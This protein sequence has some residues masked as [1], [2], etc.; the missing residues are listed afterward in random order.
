L[1]HLPCPM[2]VCS[3]SSCV[4]VQASG[5]DGGRFNFSTVP[6]DRA[7]AQPYRRRCPAIRAPGSGSHSPMRATEII[8]QAPARGYLRA[9]FFDDQGVRQGGQL[10]QM[11]NALGFN[12]FS[13]GGF[14]CPASGP[15]ASANWIP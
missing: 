4:S 6:K 7:P 15:V 13:A 2:L 1:C 10:C 8:R 11:K 12:G 9:L 14:R 5:E 3:P